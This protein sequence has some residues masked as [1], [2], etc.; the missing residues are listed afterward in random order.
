[1]KDSQNIS[2][3]DLL[4]TLNTKF[5]NLAVDV[6]I[7]G[8]GL[9]GKVMKL[10]QRM[11][12]RDLEM[13]SYPFKDWK[14]LLEWVKDIKANIKFILFIGTPIVALVI[15]LISRIFDRLLGL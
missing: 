14:V 6:K 12:D 1:M 9:T 4:I 11:D 7:M 15:A 3:H 13:A 10:E 5:D 2:D 8:D